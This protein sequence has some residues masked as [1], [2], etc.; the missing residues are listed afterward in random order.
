MCRIWIRYRPNPSGAFIA[1]F[2]SFFSKLPGTQTQ[3]QLLATG[4]FQGN[5]GPKMAAELIHLT[6]SN[7]IECSKGH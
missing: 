2:G 5:L 3:L 7:S 4:P 1:Q 6:Q